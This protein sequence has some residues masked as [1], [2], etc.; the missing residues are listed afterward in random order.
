MIQT[1]LIP[2]LKEN[3]HVK[4]LLIL[5]MCLAYIVQYL[6]NSYIFVFFLVGFCV[7][8]FLFSISVAQTLPRYFGVGMFITGMIINILKGNAIEGTVNGI[9][10]NL[11]VLSLVILVPL[12]TIPFKIGGY[13]DSIHFYMEKFAL[14]LRNLFGS[15]TIL[16]F[17]LGPILNIGTIRI[18]H[19]MIKDIKLAPEI[20]AKSYLV[21]F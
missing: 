16:M 10:A 7:V 15:I 4:S 9:L 19:E 13:F 11:P 1:K 14:R 21:G 8:V 3:V 17:C 12:L 2:R 18:L 5:A 6:T 20:L